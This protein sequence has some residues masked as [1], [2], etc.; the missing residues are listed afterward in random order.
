VL[1][2]TNQHVVR[3]DGWLHD[4]DNVKLVLADGRRLVR[5]KGINRYERTTLEGAPMARAYLARTAPFWQAVRARWSELL[6]GTAPVVV[7]FKVAD[8]TLYDHLFP[9]ADRTPLPA[10]PELAKEVASVIGAYAKPAPAR[11]ASAA[12]TAR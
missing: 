6:A 4:Q 7:T 10:A 8:K 1:V 5:E 11:S 2:G 9:L 12:T 3:D